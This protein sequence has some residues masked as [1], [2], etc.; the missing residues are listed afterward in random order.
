M[1]SLGSLC[2]M[3]GSGGL[4]LLFGGLLALAGC[5][6]QEDAGEPKSNGTQ[7]GSERPPIEVLT[8]GIGGSDQAPQ[9]LEALQAVSRVVYASAPNDPHRLSVHLAGP[10]HARFRIAADPE[11]QGRRT[12]HYYHEG[13]GYS[14]QARSGTSEPL[15]ETEAHNLAARAALREEL[16]RWSLD[17]GW[18]AL[19][20]GKQWTK[21]VAAQVQITARLPEQGSPPDR[22]TLTRNGVPV[23]TFGEIHWSAGG[24]TAL[25]VSN[26]AGPLWTETEIEI[27]RPM[28]LRPSYFL[29]PDRREPSQSKGTPLPVDALP[30]ETGPGD[31]KD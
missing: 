29:P 21:T 20:E 11:T 14:T 22:M 1:G 12:L 30:I 27:R 26:E 16:Y 2:Q 7:A 6:G 25:T 17:R 4:V 28:T 5:G 31:G 10:E 3:N 15:N 19:P 13:T 8:P 24:P 23:L 18:Q 9:E